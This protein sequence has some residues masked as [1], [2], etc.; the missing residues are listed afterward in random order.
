MTI[1]ATARIERGNIILSERSQSQKFTY[2]MIS[3]TGK[4][5]RGDCVETQNQISGYMR[6]GVE[7]IGVEGG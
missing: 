5:R 4:S 2:Y 1:Q 7:G 6:L 3:F